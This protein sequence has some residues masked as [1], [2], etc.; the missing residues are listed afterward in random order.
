MSFSATGNLLLGSDKRPDLYTYMAYET[1]K[2]GSD[3]LDGKTEIPL[4]NKLGFFPVVSTI[5]GIGRIL[6]GI[7]HTIVHLACA[8]FT[9]GKLRQHH[10]E[11]AALGAKHIVRG[12]VESIAIIGNILLVIYDAKRCDK[13]GQ[14]IEQNKTAYNHYAALFA[15]GK[16][17]A[18]RPL[19]EYHQET[20]KLNRQPTFDEIKRIILKA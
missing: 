19:D 18:K 17:I 4:I 7:V 3:S 8:I 13:L 14:Q 12:L 11:E 6:L 20:A 15:N 5:T 16:E 1:K 9:T 2:D 10:L